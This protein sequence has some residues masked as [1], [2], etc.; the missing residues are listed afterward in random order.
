MRAWQTSVF[1][2]ENLF[3]QSALWMFVHYHID[4]NLLFYGH[5]SVT[6]LTTVLVRT[7]S[8]LSYSKYVPLAK[9]ACE[10]LTASPDPFFVVK[11]C[12]TKLEKNGYQKLDG[13]SSAFTGQLIAGGKYYYIVEYSTIV[14]FAVG[15]KFI[16]SKAFG[17]HI[18]GG[19]TDSP[20]LKLKPR[21]K[22]NA[23]GCTLLG[24]QCYGK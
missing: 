9:K 10:F 5:A 24:V 11:N 3:F 12:V 22:R 23:S 2:S 7:M 21:S 20:N 1:A 13:S 8:S 17:F 4:Y 15:P 19:H 14:A 16:P 18:I 6:V